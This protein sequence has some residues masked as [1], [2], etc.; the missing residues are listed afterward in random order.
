MKWCTWGAVARFGSY[1]TCSLAALLILVAPSAR[2]I[3]ASA[4][5]SSAAHPLASLEV[6]RQTQRASCGPAALATLL[7]W[8]G[9]QVSEARLIDLA[10][11]GP[12]G[13]SLG[14]FARLA[15]SFDVTGSWYQSPISTLALLPTPFVAHL[16]LPGAAAAGHL[17]VVRSV[18]QGY[19]IVADPAQGAQVMAL[20]RF[21]RSYSGRAYLLG[22]PS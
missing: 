3:S 1:A 17:V 2:G 9:R 22:G 11:L 8:Q 21:G 14:E 15:H 6:V 19:V 7:A 18:T 16:E 4:A 10:E 13:I 12:E 5:W 20:E